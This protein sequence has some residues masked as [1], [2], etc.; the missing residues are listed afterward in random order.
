MKNEKQAGITYVGS[1]DTRELF[2]KEA[3]AANTDADGNFFA[4]AAGRN[5][6]TEQQMLDR[7]KFLADEMDANDEENR[8]MQSEIDTL[9]AKIDSAKITPN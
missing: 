5:V 9:Y 4:G 1:D 7:I 6:M 8:D 3:L 2:S